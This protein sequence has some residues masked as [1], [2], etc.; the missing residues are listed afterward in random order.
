[1]RWR[2]AVVCGASLALVGGVFAVATAAGGSQSTPAHE[3]PPQTVPYDMVFSFVEYCTP[4]DR[5]GGYTR[6][7][8]LS[9][10][11][12]NSEGTVTINLV[13]LD[14]KSGAPVVDEVATA[15]ANVCLSKRRIQRDVSDRFPNQA[16]VLVIR[17][18]FW[19][20]E[21]PC[22]TAHGVS[23]RTPAINEMLESRMLSWYLRIRP[24]DADFETE[25]AA[26]RACRPLP[27]YLEDAGIGF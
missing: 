4:P 18:W 20:W 22:L 10:W 3:R 6:L 11:A 21:A 2:F 16:Q 24:L 23:L 1:M 27:P 19:R 17:D 13:Y 8:G 7:D 26:R 15:V 12:I 14:Q 9:S 25:L 5:A